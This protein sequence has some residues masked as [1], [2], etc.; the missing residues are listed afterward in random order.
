MQKCKT[1]VPLHIQGGYV[2]LLRDS[3]PE[4]WQYYEHTRAKHIVLEKYLTAWIR[5]LGGVNPRICF[6][7]CFAGRGEYTRG[8]PGSPLVALRVADREA[9]RF[10]R[11]TCFFIDNDPDNFKNLSEVLAREEPRLR[12]RSKI[13]IKKE[14]AEFAKVVGSLFEFLEKEGCVLVPSFFFI[15]PFGFSDVPFSVVQK[16]MANPRTEV[17][18]TF[19]VRDIRRFLTR[20]PLEATFSDLFATDKWKDIVSSSSRPELALIDLYRRQLHEAAG[21]KFSWCFRVCT[22]V[23]IQTLYYLIH[24]TNNVLG[25]TIMK[26]I[27]FKQS[28]AGNFE[29]LGPR[30]I[31]AGLQLRLFDIQDIGE[32][33]LHL[34]ERFSGRAISYDKIQEEI[35][36]PWD[37]EPPYVDQHYRKALKQ[38][39]RDGKVKV[40]RVSSKKRGLKKDDLI[41]FP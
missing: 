34:L 23:S 38:L 22:D 37:T 31:Q 9:S 39:E 15:D 7:D 32:L 16:I 25:H 10:G 5:I 29:Y 3:A 20:S 28:Q 12:N 36:V 26:G 30:E 17:F 27:M 41:V 40:T 35:C 11:L 21:V 2:N 13:R 4:K 1:Q 14:N 18:F 19:M 6:F 8:Q 33:R 24:A